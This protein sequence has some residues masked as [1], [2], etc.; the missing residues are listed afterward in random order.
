MENKTVVQFNDVRYREFPHVLF[1]QSG[2]GIIYFDAAACIG[3]EKNG[4]N[5]SVPAFS[6][7]F[8]WWIHI[9]SEAYGVPAGKMIIQN[10][11]EGNL[12]LEESLF[13]PFMAYLDAAFAVYM[14]ERISE[15]LVTGI[16]LSDSAL[17]SMARDRLGGGDL[18]HMDADG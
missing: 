6:E 7:K 1:G 2:D 10:G 16:V 4:E 11:D 12:L 17:V 18:T 9:L 13:L 3:K 8:S 15:M 5:H 14:L